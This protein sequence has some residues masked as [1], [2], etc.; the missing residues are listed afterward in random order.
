MFADMVDD[1]RER[2]QLQ[3]VQSVDA[4]LKYFQK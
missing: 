3:V 2:L 1:G 4:Q